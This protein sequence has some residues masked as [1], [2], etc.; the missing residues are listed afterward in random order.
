MTLDAQ[1]TESFD[2]ICCND[3][4][5]RLKEVGQKSNKLLPENQKKKDFRKRSFM[6]AQV[7][8]DD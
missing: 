7:R 8:L 3:G 5:L 2:E 1:N 6:S 4:N